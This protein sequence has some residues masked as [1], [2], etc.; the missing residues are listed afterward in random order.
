MT[1]VT[2]LDKVGNII[3]GFSNPYTPNPNV[4]VDTTL[5]IITFTDD[6]SAT[7]TNSDSINITIT[8]DNLDVA[9]Y[10]FSTDNTCDTSDTYGNIVTSG[11]P[12]TIDSEGYNGQYICV[13]AEDMAG[14]RTYWAS[15]DP[16]NIDI[17][18]PVI[19]LVGSDPV[20]QEVFT[21]YVDAGA[22]ALDDTDGDITGSIMGVNPVDVNTVGSY[23]V[24]Y[25]VNDAAGNAATQVTRT[26]DIVDTTAPTLT[27]NGAD[28]LIH[29]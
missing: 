4:T 20:T 18:A 17:V 24:T 8:E 27:L 14:N 1:G 16:L 26:V 7:I 12:F 5:P 21:P 19:T 15:A 11:T 10:G 2:F 25:D 28:P 9:E 29:E 13:F 23:T 3:T 22:T 6:V